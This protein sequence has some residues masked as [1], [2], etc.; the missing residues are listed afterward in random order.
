[1]LTSNDRFTFLEFYQREMRKKYA[2]IMLNINSFFPLI[3]YI[4]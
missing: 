4:Y 1:M 2:K 3:E